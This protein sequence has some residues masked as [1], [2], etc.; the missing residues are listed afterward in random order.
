M[1]VQMPEMDGLEATR[2]IIARCGTDRPRIV[3]LTADAMQD[4]RERCLSAGMDDY[5]TKPI[6]PAELA[7]ALERAAQPATTTLEPGALDRLLETAGGDIEFVAVLLETFAD[8]AP[9]LL[10]EL[11]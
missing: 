8:E 11:R 10:D 1:D 7:Q 2:S 3:A 6:R 9:A 4:D 5:L